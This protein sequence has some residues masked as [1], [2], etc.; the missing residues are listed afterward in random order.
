MRIGMTLLTSDGGFNL[1]LPHVLFHIRMVDRMV[2]IANN[3]SKMLKYLLNHLSEKFPTF[4][5]MGGVYRDFNPK[6]QTVWVNAMIQKLTKMGMDWIINCD[7]DEFY[8]GPVR[9]TIDKIEKEGFNTMHTNGYCFYSTEKDKYNSNPIRSMTYRDPNDTPYGYKKMI[10]K[11]KNFLTTTD[12]NHWIKFKDTPLNTY[13]S[14]KITI[15]HYTHRPKSMWNG[16]C[17]LHSEESIKKNKFVIDERLPLLFD[18]MG[19]EI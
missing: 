12:G 8:Y 11:T 19:L 2:C 16:R 4:E 15:F 17:V 1:I 5:Y 14:S 9:H 13:E 10:H 3:P 6:R 18:K 7:E